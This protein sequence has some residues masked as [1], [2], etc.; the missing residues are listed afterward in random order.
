MPSGAKMVPAHSKQ[1]ENYEV[2]ILQ[3][4]PAPKI[5]CFDKGSQ[6]TKGQFSEKDIS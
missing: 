2:A 6:N 3:K 5:S 1:S 4:I